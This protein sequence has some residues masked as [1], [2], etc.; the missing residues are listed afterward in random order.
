LVWEG[1]RK[2][3]DLTALPPTLRRMAFRGWPDEAVEFY[4]GLL[5]DN[6]KTYWQAH[7]STYD[8]CVLAPMKELLAELAPEFGAGKVFR[9]YR[10]VRFSK[11]KTPYKT[12]IGATTEKGGY[13]QFSADG[14]A[15]GCGIYGMTPEQLAD[16]RSAVDSERSGGELAA[17]VAAARKQG[18]DVMAHDRVATAPRGFAKDHPRIELLRL[19]GLASWQQ[20]PVG[21]WLGTAKAKTRVVTFLRCSQPLHTWLTEYVAAPGHP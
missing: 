4:E 9:P 5:A 15:A 10:D 18:L 11:D 12:A 3:G 13:V 16:Y 8:A 14:L 17:I 6:T 21:A 7:K 20:W 2:P 1:R 19:K